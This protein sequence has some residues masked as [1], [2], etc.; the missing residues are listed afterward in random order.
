MAENKTSTATPGGNTSPGKC[1]HCLMEDVEIVALNPDGSCPRCKGNYSQGVAGN[2]PPKGSQ[3]LPL[4][5]VTIPLPPFRIPGRAGKYRQGYAQITSTT[6]A[7][8]TKRPDDV[9][10]IPVIVFDNDAE[11]RLAFA[12]MLEMP[13]GK[14]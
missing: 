12:R 11:L 7:I 8:Y 14:G 5:T 1:G 9:A 6:V 4:A 10:L 2:S 3:E 13:N